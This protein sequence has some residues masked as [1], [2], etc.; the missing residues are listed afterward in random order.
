MTTKRGYAER[1]PCGSTVS[2]ADVSRETAA[3]WT[4]I[5]EEAE[6]AA[7]C[8]T[9]T[10]T[11]MPRPP[12][13]RVLTVA[14]QKGGVG[15][16]TSTVNLAVALALHGIRVLVID[17]DPQGNATTALGVDA[18]RRH[19]VGLRVLLGEISLAEAAVPSP[20]SPEPA[21]ASRPRST[22]PA[23]RSSWCRMVARETG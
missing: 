4:P 14:N 7:G 12:H 1:D 16:T 11:G 23:P 18:P 20:A 22:W 19:A 3:G 2:R 21:A 15:K 8:C 6:R 9:P 10:G 13:R 5:A 17:L